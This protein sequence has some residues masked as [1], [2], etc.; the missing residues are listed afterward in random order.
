MT[1]LYF[2]L[3]TTE[4][5]SDIAGELRSLGVDDNHIHIFSKDTGT[6]A[7]KTGVHPAT[8]LHVSDAWHMAKQGAVGGFLCGLAAL[9]L[10]GTAVMEGM[11]TIALGGVI[12]AIAGAVLCFVIGVGRNE[13]NIELHQKDIAQGMTMLLV[14]VDKQKKE[15]VIQVVSASHSEALVEESSGNLHL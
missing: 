5:A 4:S 10:A 3:P 8:V 2:T 6:D 11:D 14:D 7:K 12:G 13:L 1:R 15:S 9:L